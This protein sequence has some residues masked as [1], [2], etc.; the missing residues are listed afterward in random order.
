MF[1]GKPF[2][3]VA[4]VNALGGA[5]V[6]AAEVPNGEG[7]SCAFNTTE[8]WPN[9]EDGAVGRPNASAVVVGWPKP[10]EDWPRPALGRPSVDDWPKEDGWPN[11]DDGCPKALGCRLNVDGWPNAEG[12]PKVD[13]GADG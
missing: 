5:A 2:G 12:W 13:V 6:C 3:A 8:G 9:A 10:E 4:W 1:D 11:V 7:L